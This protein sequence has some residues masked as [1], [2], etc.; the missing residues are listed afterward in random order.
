MSPDCP[1]IG[2]GYPG[3]GSG[4]GD[5]LYRLKEGVERFLITDINNPAGSAAAQSSIWVML[6]LVAGIEARM[7]GTL[8][9]TVQAFNH[10]PG[11][12]NVLFMDGHVEFMKY[13]M[14]GEFPANGAMAY[15]NGN[16]MIQQPE[17]PI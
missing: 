4:G 2:C 13:R 15:F 16:T 12:A 8:R 3:A 7:N 5:I 14:E 17:N 1:P 6:D 10:V 11:G 9:N